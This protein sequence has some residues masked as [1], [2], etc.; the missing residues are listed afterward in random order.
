MKVLVTGANGFLGR[1][2]VERLLRHGFNDIRC[3][4]RPGKDTIELRRFGERF[5]S[6]NVNL[7]V[8]DLRSR[9]Y[10]RRA[11]DGT[12]VVYHLAAG[13]RGSAADLCQN[14][15]VSSRNMLE[16]MVSSGSARVVLVSSFA[17]YGTSDLE[18]GSLID[19]T[20]P[21]EEHPERR[22]L[23]AFSKIRQERLFWEYRRQYG[24]P[25]IVI[26]PGVVYGPGGVAMST[27]VG[28]RMF[29]VLF[30]FGR[31]NLLPLTYVDNCAEAIVVAGKQN[32]GDVFNVVDDDLVT[33]NEFLDLYRRRVENVRYVPIPYFMTM[34]ISRMVAWY[35]VHSNG[36]LPDVLTPYKSANIWKGYK[37]DNSKMKSAG[38]QPVISTSEGLERFWS[39]WR[40]EVHGGGTTRE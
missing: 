21:L 2:L 7:C 39:Y 15:V 9:E 3:A 37:F 24:I 31:K 29:G 14:T 33:A 5:R 13:M 26:R 17:V 19:E 12:D 18:S 10:A 1:S 36:Q 27:R 8:G 4:V 28:I 20:T 38:W 40:D 34:T 16:A 22:D 32:D 25:L 23:Y 30:N 35:H 11:V 6:A